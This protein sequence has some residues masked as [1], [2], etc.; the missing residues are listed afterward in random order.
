MHAVGNMRH[1][2]FDLRPS[3]KQCL[4]D[5][6]A[7]LSVQLADTVDGATSTD[8]QIRHVEGLRRIVLVS[9]SQRQQ[10]VE[11]DRKFLLRRNFL[12]YL[13]IRSGSETVKAS[14]NGSVGRKEISGTRD[15]QRQIEWLLILL[16]V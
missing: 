13:S 14:L 12:R 16:H 6:P 3:R 10:I 7:H 2:H 8:R 9:P 15:R 11:R 5:S 4:K 1:R